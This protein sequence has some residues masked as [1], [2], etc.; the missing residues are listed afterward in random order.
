M[1]IWDLNRKGFSQADIGRRMDATRQAAYDALKV[2]TEKVDAALRHA[3][4]ANMIE[5]RKVDPTNGILLGF[6]PSNRNNVIVTFSMKHGIQT[7]HY[8]SPDC[9]GCRWTER[10]RGRLIDEA[11]E[12]G[13]KLG[14]A[15]KELQPARLAH[16]IFSRLIQGLE[17]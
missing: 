10:C 9:P 15:E 14:E 7:W 13:I 4:E 3:A 11:E 2:A 17:P 6:S 1:Y 5:V 8:E 16:V 12:R